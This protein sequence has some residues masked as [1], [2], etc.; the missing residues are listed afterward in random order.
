MAG[1]MRMIDAFKKLKRLKK[2]IFVFL[3]CMM[4]DG[5]LRETYDSAFFYALVIFFY[6]NHVT[7][8]PADREKLAAT[9]FKSGFSDPQDLSN[10]SGFTNP[11]SPTYHMHNSRSI[12]SKFNR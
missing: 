6:W 11:T 1:T 8:D 12:S 9:R 4:L 3:L 7:M 10:P 2:I 5:V